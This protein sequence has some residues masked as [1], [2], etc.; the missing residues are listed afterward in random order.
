MQAGT[1]SRRLRRE[2]IRCSMLGQGSKVIFQKVFCTK[3]PKG[4]PRRIL[5]WNLNP[6]NAF[7]KFFH[8]NVE[9]LR[10][11]R[12]S[13][14]PGTHEMDSIW[15]PH[16]TILGQFFLYFGQL[17][18]P[19]QL[20]PTTN[21]AFNQGSLQ[22]KKPLANQAFKQ[23]SLQPTKSSTNPTF[24]QPSL[25]PTSPSTNQAFNHPSLQSPSLAFFRSSNHNR[26]LR[27]PVLV[28]E[29]RKPMLCVLTDSVN[30]A[31]IHM[32]SRLSAELRSIIVHR[33]CIMEGHPNELYWLL[34]SR[35]VAATR[36][37]VL[38]PGK[39]VKHPSNPLFVEDQTWEA[40]YDNFYGTVIYDTS[41]ANHS[42]KCWYNPFTQDR[43]A[44]GMSLEQRQQEP[45]RPPKNCQMSVCYA[46]SSGGIHWTKPHLDLI[47]HNGSTANNIVVKSVQW[48][49]SK[50]TK[51]TE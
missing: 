36:N 21:P 2:L 38:L 51:I 46:I 29:C 7:F 28:R 41:N 17:P 11:F 8:Q 31:Y 40:R 1:E 9:K 43:S 50:I 33:G 49:E 16:G 24:Y 27:N 44:Q 20:Y 30:S 26:I 3:G 15:D 45:Y 23:P 42:Y 34:N 10:G 32:C 6:S 14:I 18:P 19:T 35:A 22:P 13:G 47:E 39:V 37:L 48:L 4:S 12:A 5:S 25:Q